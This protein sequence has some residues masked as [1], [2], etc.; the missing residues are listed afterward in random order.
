MTATS[1]TVTGLTNGTAYVFRV[2]AAN[3]VGTGPW[4]ATSAAYT[5][6]ATVPGVPTGVTGSN[7]TATSIDVS[8]TPPADDGGSPVMAY[9]L[10]MSSHWWCAVDVRVASDG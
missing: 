1:Y 10:R 8:W 6:Q 3:A 4:S 9:V 7:A 5:P 2:A